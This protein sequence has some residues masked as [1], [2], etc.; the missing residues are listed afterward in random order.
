[1]ST[2]ALLPGADIALHGGTGF[3]TLVLEFAQNSVTA[4]E[5]MPVAMSGI[6]KIDIE[7]KAST[8]WT[9]SFADIQNLSDTNR[10]VFDGNTG[11]TI[12]LENTVAKNSLLRRPVGSG[13]DVRDVRSERSLRALRLRQ[14]RGRRG[15]GGDRYRHRCVADLIV[16][17]RR[18]VALL[19]AGVYR[20]TPSSTGRLIA[21]ATAISA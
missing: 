3:D 6:E 17:P 20:I 16:A 5:G 21:T 18:R 7:D 1:M 8:D 4:I 10:I 12:Y 14:E 9:F 13:R 11:D 2:A 15:V 19:P